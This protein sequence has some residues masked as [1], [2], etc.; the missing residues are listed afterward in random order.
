MSEPLQHIAKLKQRYLFYRL[1][2]AGLWSAGVACLVFSLSKLWSDSFLLR[3]TCSVLS[4]LIIGTA[5]VI[6]QRL[7]SRS[8][9]D[10]TR[11]LNQ[12]YPSLQQ[13]ADL[14]VADSTTLSRLERMQQERTAMEFSKIYPVIRLPHKLVQS[15]VILLASIA[16]SLLLSAFLPNV[17]SLRVSDGMSRGESKPVKRPPFSIR[18]FEITITPPVYTRLSSFT[19]SN[20]DVTLPE[21]SRVGWKLRFSGEVEEM[22]MIFS[23]RDSVL[24][25]RE[26]EYVVLERVFLQS[27][28]YQLKWKD[29]NQTQWS[30]FYRID[31]TPD[32]A[33]KIAVT[34]L[35]QFTR[36]KYA[37]ALEVE[38]LSRLSDDYALTDAGII[39]TVSKGSGEGIKF[40]EERLR[41]ASPT[42]IQGKQVQAQ[43]KLNL[44]K[45][46]LEPGDELY[47]YI[48]AFDNKTPLPNRS[49]TETFFI[50]VQDTVKS[51]A[52]ED[53][54]LGVDLMPDYF[55]SQRQIIIDTEKLLKD[56]PRISKQQFNATSNELGF[57]Q[58]T[59]RLKYGQFLG[60]EEDSGIGTEAAA[61]PDEG[62]EEDVTKPFSHQHDKDNEHNLV[63]EKKHDHHEQSAD[64]DKKE[65][66]LAAFVHSHDN[67]EVATFFEQSLRAKLKAA[68][69]VMW[70]AELHLRLYQPE[71][72]LPYQYTALKLLKEISNDSRIYVHRTGF[73]PPPLKEEK[74][75]TADLSE[76]KNPTNAHQ[77]ES[78]TDY[79]HLREA[80]LLAEKLLQDKD[81]H[82][83]ASGQNTFQRAGQE[84]APLA[85]K[86]PALLPALSL[87]K[88]LA[89]K[90]EQPA[91]RKKQL[92]QLHKI[93]WQVLPIKSAAPTQQATAVHALD[94][95]FIQQLEGKENE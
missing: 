43:A 57:D 54:G 3:M 28:F 75:L 19:S 22:K 5:R 52:V 33:P 87:L 2:E 25:K 60:E 49:R 86:Q 34:N 77:R 93:L 78:E 17:S 69:T 21:G 84:F 7:F 95:L 72:S 39:A 4:G 20:F 10:F 36:L 80:L 91:E 50:A 13:S 70:D 64:P 76:V 47:F 59:L 81:I 74:R 85:L 27:G 38:V 24:M 44:K 30:D 12:H 68:L 42:L 35:N 40:R 16:L 53:E 9:A 88:K 37:D 8:V 11:F 66:P 61:H 55:R 62:E 83:T 90:E 18:S 94:Q 71:K 32:E 29:G 51:E 58:K 15:S 79:V 73:E 41:F 63:Q 14:L 65:D 1:A 92:E 23:N 6:G 56:K 48:E 46:G 89:E 67:S 31:I 26:G 82:I 45:L